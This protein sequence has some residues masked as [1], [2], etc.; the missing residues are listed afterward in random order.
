MN[1]SFCVCCLFFSGD[2]NVLRTI[3]LYHI[4]NGIFIGGGL[5]AGVTNL[6]KSLQGSNLKVM[7]VSSAARLNIF[8][9]KSINCI[10]SLINLLP[11]SIKVYKMYID[12][13]VKI[14]FMV[15]SLLSGQI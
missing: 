8:Y 13:S 3:L 14:S 1:D 6:L 7:F 15:V 10:L 11:L 5:E 2:I 12:Y 4:N 9:L